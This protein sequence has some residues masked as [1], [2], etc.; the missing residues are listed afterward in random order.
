MPMDPVSSSSSEGTLFVTVVLAVGASNEAWAHDIAEKAL[1]DL[2]PQGITVLDQD[3]NGCWV[4]RATV[5]VAYGPDN[6]VS[7]AVQGL[8]GRMQLG[9]GVTLLRISAIDDARDL[10]KVFENEELLA[11]LRE[12]G[13]CSE[14]GAR[15]Y[16]HEECMCDD[17]GDAEDVAD[18]FDAASREREALLGE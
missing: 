11:D 5:G 3:E 18:E 16:R 9:S 12:R 10:V 7:S 13:T 8:P 14:C 1:E 17:G 15:T 6:P 2:S 4:T